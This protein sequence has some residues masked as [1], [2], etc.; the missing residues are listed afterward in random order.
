MR[1]DNYIV[2]EEPGKDSKEQ[3]IY[4]RLETIQTSPL[5]GYLEESWRSEEMGC[6]WDPSGEKHP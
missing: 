4:G 2:S 5:L 3:D 6:H 1:D